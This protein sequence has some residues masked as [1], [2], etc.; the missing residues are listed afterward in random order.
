MPLSERLSVHRKEKQE[1]SSDNHTS[2]QNV[3]GTDGAPP[4]YA[5][6]AA[7]DAPAADVLNAA[8]ANLKISEQ[9][10]LAFPDANLCLAHLKLLTVFHN[11]KEDI[12]YTD[13]L[14][15]LWDSRCDIAENRGEAL[16]K[17]REKRWALYIARAVER[18]Q[19]WWLKVLCRQEESTRLTRNEM[20]ASNRRF[21]DF[22]KTG[23]I[24]RWDTAG[25]PPIG[26]NN[27]SQM[28][29]NDFF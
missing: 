10:N 2:S 3:E 27:Y 15:D 7:L 9:D 14:F 8:F 29:K 6:P 18:F 19:E 20:A 24:R 4:D 13:G 11:L 17:T 25:L 16:A 28:T 22:P 12:G 21:I 26:M 5:A 23:L 1:Q